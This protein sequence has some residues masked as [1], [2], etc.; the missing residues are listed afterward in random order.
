[1][2]LKAR[3]GAAGG[4]AAGGAAAAAAA[5]R[6]A[7]AGGVGDPEQ[8]SLALGAGTDRDGT[9]LLEGGGKEEGGKRSPPG[10]GLLAKTPLS[11]PVKRNHAK[12]RR[13]QTLIYDALERPRGWALLYHAFV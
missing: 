8:G 5:G 4:S 9:L 6:R 13:I 11:R 7:A 12:Y 1:M 2:G 10:L 3:R